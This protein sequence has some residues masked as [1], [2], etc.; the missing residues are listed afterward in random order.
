MLRY[1]KNVIFVYRFECVTIIKYSM[2]YLLKISSIGSDEERMEKVSGSLLDVYQY[3]KETCKAGEVADIYG[4]NE[5]IETAIRLD[6]SVANLTH[7]L[8]W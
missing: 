8:E 3:M 5:Y 2:E 1:Q 4:E 7:K 6:S